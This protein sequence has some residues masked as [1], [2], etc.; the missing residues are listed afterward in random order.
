MPCTLAFLAQMGLVSSVFPTCHKASHLRLSRSNASFSP[1]SLPATRPRT[2]AFLAQMH[3][4]HRFP[5]SSLPATLAP[6]PSL[7]WT[8]VNNA[9]WPRRR[10]GPF[11]LKYI[12]LTGL[13]VPA[14]SQTLV[15]RTCRLLDP[16]PSQTSGLLTNLRSLDR[17]CEI[18]PGEP[19]L[20]HSLALLFLTPCLR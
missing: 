9:S 20:D 19:Q 6:S 10:W 17:A 8:A 3:H 11:S 7:L 13:V 1:D 2:L 5:P 16:P 12:V 15:H 14:F 4:S 18:L